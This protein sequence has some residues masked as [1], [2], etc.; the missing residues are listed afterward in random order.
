MFLNSQFVDGT[1][2]QKDV[3]IQNLTSMFTTE[4]AQPNAGP[5]VALT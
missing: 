1:Y 3:D 2:Q 4:Y 5:K